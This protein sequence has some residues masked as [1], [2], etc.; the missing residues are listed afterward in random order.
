MNFFRSREDAAGWAKGRNGI[1]I[2]SV[3]EGDELAQY[4]WV[5]R[6]RLATR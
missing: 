6:K 2:L 3:S 5:E 1:A 4:I